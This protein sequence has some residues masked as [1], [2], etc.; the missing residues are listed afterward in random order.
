MTGLTQIVAFEK[1]KQRVKQVLMTLFEAAA[2]LRVDPSL[3]IPTD[4]FTKNHPSFPQQEIIQTSLRDG[5]MYALRPD[6]TTMLMQQWLP[7]LS[8]REQ[9]RVYYISNHYRQ[10]QDGVVLTN[11]CGFEVYGTFSLIDQLSM[12]ETIFQVCQK[13]VT[14]VVGF[15]SLM[16][17]FLNQAGIGSALRYAIKTKSIRE[18]ALT[19]P[20]LAQ[21]LTKYFTVY[22]SVAD[23]KALVDAST[24]ATLASVK[25]ACPN[26]TI[27][28]DLS[29]IPDFDYYSGIYL[30]GYMQGYQAP[31]LFGGSYDGRTNQYGQPM[32]AFGVSINMDMLVEE[33]QS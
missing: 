27:K 28:F 32:Q 16:N 15:P 12:L 10:N 8:D 25:E 19:S 26:L 24:Y 17:P 30:K 13:P 6:I 7:L 14:L 11:E 9:L 21:T 20:S 1:N 33:V 4:T 31:I 5:I 23:V 3:L 22:D 2:F 29:L 18:L